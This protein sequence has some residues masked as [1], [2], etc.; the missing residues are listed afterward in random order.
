MNRKRSKTDPTPWIP[1]E[2]SVICSIHFKEG[3]PTEK[4]P[5]PTLNLGYDIR[6]L[7]AGAIA[8]PRKSATAHHAVCELVTESEKAKSST[9]KDGNACIETNELIQPTN[10]EVIVKQEM[11]VDDAIG[12]ASIG[13]TLD[14]GNK[15]E[16]Y[17]YLRKQLDELRGQHMTKCMILKEITHELKQLK[18]PLY[19]RILLGDADFKFYTGLPNSTVFQLVLKYVQ[20][21]QRL[22]QRKSPSLTISILRYK[23]RSKQQAPSKKLVFPDQILL[24]LMKLR[25]GLIHK[26][27]ADR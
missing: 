23:Q 4:N 7:N 10:S 3:K 19:Q 8:L 14:V 22:S 27:L 18:R 1:D 16:D 13:D 17:S 12:P 20:A 21:W 6:N 15:Y 11:G 2:T 24:V 9:V 25:L 26:D 5:L